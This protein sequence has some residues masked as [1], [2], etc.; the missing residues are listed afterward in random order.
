L[1][2]YENSRRYS[3]SDEL[4]IPS[5]A[6]NTPF[7]SDHHPFSYFEDQTHED[8]DENMSGLKNVLNLGKRF[9][10]A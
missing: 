3:T 2:E 1:E 8:Q 9:F 7:V 5:L 6:D 10:R 4:H